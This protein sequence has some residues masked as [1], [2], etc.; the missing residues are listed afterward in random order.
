M[1]SSWWPR[2]PEAPGAVSTVL[3]A[4]A[5][6]LLLRWRP[7]D[8]LPAVL[9]PRGPLPPAPA[10]EQV[11]ALVARVDRLLAAGRP[12]VRSGCLVRGLTL[13]RV[14][15][16]AGAEVSLR[17]GVGVIGGQPGGRMA[18]HCWLVYQGEPLAEPRDPRP[19]FAETWSIP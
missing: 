16:R 8:R 5:V 14:L 3:F 9:A 18:A 4:A 17:F 7:L 2:S 12:L 13:Y 19:L 6:P 11:A 10:P 1:R 15:R